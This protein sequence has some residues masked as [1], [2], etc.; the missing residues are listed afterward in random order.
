MRVA[1]II[2]NALLVKFD[3]RPLAGICLGLIGGI[4]ALSILAYIAQRKPWRIEM[5]ARLKPRSP[6]R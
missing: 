1:L 5:R 4:I 3:M 6:G 2:I